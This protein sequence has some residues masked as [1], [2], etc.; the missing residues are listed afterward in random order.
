MSDDRRSLNSIDDI[1]FAVRRIEELEAKLTNQTH[2]IAQVFALL[3]VTEETEDGRVFHPTQ[4][5]SSRVLDA[6]K[7]DALLAE[8]KGTITANDKEDWDAL[9]EVTAELEQAEAR[10]E[11]LSNCVAVLEA[12]L[13]KSEALLTK[14]VEAERVYCANVVKHFYDNGFSTKHDD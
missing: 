1:E 9:Q 3:D 10:I 6:E 12:K 2:M 4:I 5:R 8:L 13:S 11:E 14:A 7:L